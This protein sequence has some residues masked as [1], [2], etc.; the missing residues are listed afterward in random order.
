LV[1]V[2]VVDASPELLRWRIIMPGYRRVENEN[3]W[4]SSH[5]EVVHRE[6]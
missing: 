4:A 6:P 5:P 2:A 1:V 3:P